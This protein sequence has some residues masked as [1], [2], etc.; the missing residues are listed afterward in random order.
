MASAAVLA[1]ANNKSPTRADRVISGYGLDPLRLVGALAAT[2]VI[3]QDATAKERI[4][5]K[6]LKTITVVASLGGGGSDQGSCTLD[7]YPMG[8][9]ATTDDTDGATRL[10]VVAATQDTAADVSSEEQLLVTLDVEKYDYVEL[11]AKA[12]NTASDQTT[13]NWVDVFA[14]A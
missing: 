5:V 13:V 6:G 9:G 1:P 3:L 8:F 2:T 14:T 7:L 10:T 11:E 4:Y 12:S